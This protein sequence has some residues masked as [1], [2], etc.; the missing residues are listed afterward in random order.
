[1]PDACRV[2]LRERH[3][4]G[5]RSSHVAYLV[6]ALTLAVLIHAG[7]LGTF[8][9]QDDIT[10]LRRATQP[11]FPAEPTRFLSTSVAFRLE[12]AAFGLDPLGY[13]V[14]NLLLHLANVAGV[15]FLGLRLLG[16]RGKAVAAAI[17]FGA[18]SIAFTPLH[19]ASGIIELLACALLIAA[20][21]TL[22][23]LPSS[24]PR[25]WLVALLLLAAMLAKETA[26]AW[27]GFAALACRVLDRAPPQRA[28]GYPAIGITVAYLA[29]YLLTGTGLDRSPSGAYALSASP[30]FLLRNLSTYVVW[31]VALW[32]T[33]RDVI[34]LADVHA[35]RVAWPTVVLFGIA[36]A[37]GDD[38][39]RTPARVGVGWW[40]AFL[41]PVLPLA[42]HTYLYYLYIPWVGGSIAVVAA[43]AGVLTRLGTRRAVLAG[44]LLVATFLAVEGRNVA[45]RR[46]ALRDHLPVDRTIREATLL[47]RALA[48]IEDAR[49]S[50]GTKIGFVNPSL[51]S[52]A[53]SDTTGS[54]Q[55]VTY[56][57]LEAALRGGE[58]IRLFF[59]GLVYV[60]FATTI[61][62]GWSDVECF[63]Y[64]QRG[65]L[66]RWGS[67]EAARLR[68]AEVLAPRS[69]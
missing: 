56:I 29:W 42:H 53:P 43:V 37:G 15:Y 4:H 32:N 50:P 58:T 47:R 69:K 13:H 65:W 25:Q 18:S 48:G 52:A 41:L 31:S 66:E 54:F 55:R 20:T 36:L 60:G 33:I 61:P 6:P 3:L 23:L 49:L 26:V 10:F 14:V 17:L 22:L 64:E 8:F 7:A 35:W 39:F 67:G 21:L 44:G 62:A 16:G 28:I 59:P 68:Q 38:S 40:L 9:A 12:H 2:R 51:R 1:M 19:W 45:T 24:A 27:I 57:P 63:R 34:A 30:D 11:L 5:L 46:S